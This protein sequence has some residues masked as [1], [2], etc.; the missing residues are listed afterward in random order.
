ML[1][2]STLFNSFATQGTSDNRNNRFY[3][4]NLDFLMY[5]MC[6]CRLPLSF[7]CLADI[8][9]S[10]TLASTVELCFINLPRLFVRHCVS[11]AQIY[12]FSNSY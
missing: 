12:I 8:S 11:G 3:I 1:S 9:L 4:H 2:V 7:T 10:F 5:D 6:F